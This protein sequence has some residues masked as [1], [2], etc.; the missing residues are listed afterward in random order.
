MELACRR[1]AAATA[2]TRDCPQSP[3][4]P[5]RGRRRLRPMPGGTPLRP[6][7]HGQ[8]LPAPG[9]Q[10]ARRR[11]AAP[12][13]GRPP[14]ACHPAV[15]HRTGVKQEQGLC[16]RAK[17]RIHTLSNVAANE[18]RLPARCTAQLHHGT[19]QPP[20]CA[21]LAARPASA[22]RAGWLGGPLGAAP[23]PWSMLGHHRRCRPA[24]DDQELPCWSCIVDRS[25]LLQLTL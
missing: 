24:A 9:A 3:R 23:P 2:G 11:R 20:R 1:T 4:V 5:P 18:Q 12:P 14:P 7:R 22:P 19:R 6:C 21:R 8:V 25:Q 15:M 16:T 10:Q 17:M 13:Q